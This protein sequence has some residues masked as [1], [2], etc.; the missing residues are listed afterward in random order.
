MVLLWGLFEVEAD[1][2]P[3]RAFLVM[4]V[5][6]GTETGKRFGLSVHI[7]TAL[8]RRWTDISGWVMVDLQ[9]VFT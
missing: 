7:R 5:G 2:P 3:Q 4:F 8:G 6:A 1:G 9:R